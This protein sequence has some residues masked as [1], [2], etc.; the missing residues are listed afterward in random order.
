MSAEATSFSFQAL[1]T[2]ATVAVTDPEA[3]ARA[4][5]VLERELEAIDLAC[6]RFRSDSELVRLN[7]ASGAEVR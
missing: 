5:A 2:T 3:L 7:A 4:R 6:S 1:G